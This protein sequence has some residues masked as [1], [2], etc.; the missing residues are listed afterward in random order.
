VYSVGYDADM[1]QQAPKAV[2]TSP[3]WNWGPKYVEIIKQIMAGTYKTESFWGGWKDGTVDLAPIG[4]M[5]PDDVKKMAE[6][7]IAKF[8]SGQQDI[9]AIFSGPINDQNGNLVVAA[10]QTLSADDLLSNM[11][12]FVEGVNGTA[13]GPVPT[14]VA[15]SQEKIKAALYIG[16]WVTWLELR[17]RSGATSSAKSFALRGHQ[18]C[19]ICSRRA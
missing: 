17:A 9:F 18:H 13:P 12:W 11:T 15:Q 10:G 19:R 8:K 3:V 6:D 7:E 4:S 5:V 2:L 16:P 1:S 14:P